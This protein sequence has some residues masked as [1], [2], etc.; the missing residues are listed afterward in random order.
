MYDNLAGNTCDTNKMLFLPP[1]C[2]FS[3]F[4]TWLRISGAHTQG[5]SSMLVIASSSIFVA[6]IVLDAFVY[7]HITRLFRP[8]VV[9]CCRNNITMVSERVVGHKVGALDV[10]R[11]TTMFERWLIVY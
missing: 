9:Y 2:I 4:Y 7:G 10:Y 3:H 1:T 11:T 5:L 8:F 6:V